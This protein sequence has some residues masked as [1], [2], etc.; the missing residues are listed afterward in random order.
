MV[1]KV[2]IVGF[3]GAIAQIAPLDPPLVRCA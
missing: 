2:P 3:R 1:K